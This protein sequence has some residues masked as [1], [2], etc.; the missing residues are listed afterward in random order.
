MGATEQR[1]FATAPEYKRIATLQATDDFPVLTTRHQQSIDFILRHSM[2]R[3]FF[4]D[5]D[6]LGIGAAVIEQFAR[7]EA[8]INDDIGTPHNFKSAHRD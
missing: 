1:F 5:V 6:L 4:A 2:A 8:V 3:C 7:D